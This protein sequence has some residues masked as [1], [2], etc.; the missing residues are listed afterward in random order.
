MPEVTEAGS[1]HPTNHSAAI[2]VDGT[3]RPKRGGPGK[4]RVGLLSLRFPEPHP[5][6]THQVFV[7]A[8][9][10]IARAVVS[11]TVSTSDAAT[12]ADKVWLGLLARGV[13]GTGETGDWAPG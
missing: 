11:M 7:V 9:V 2:S 3:L 8:L 4:W 5:F 10:G 1:S 12:V 13:L 6:L